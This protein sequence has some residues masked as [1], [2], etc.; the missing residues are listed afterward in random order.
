MVIKAKR[1]IRVRIIVP[2]VLFSI[3]SFKCLAQ[4][5]ALLSIGPNGALVYPYFFL[6]RV[7][8]GQVIPHS[9]GHAT[10]PFVA[11]GC[12]LDGQ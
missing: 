3:A 9:F 7:A 12:F 5:L 6:F 4:S 10:A 2:P 8:R 1:L 11:P